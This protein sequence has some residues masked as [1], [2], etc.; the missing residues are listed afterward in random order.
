M[1]DWDQVQWITRSREKGSTRTKTKDGQKE[2]TR[3]GP[4]P[5][6]HGENRQ[7]RCS[8]TRTKSSGSTGSTLADREKAELDGGNPKSYA[9]PVSKDAAGRASLPLRPR[10]NA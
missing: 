8:S 10:I 5:V 3:P 6:D 4:R 2:S 9:P 1:L 7:N